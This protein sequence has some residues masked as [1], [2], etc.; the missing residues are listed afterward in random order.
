MKKERW[1][2]VIGFEGLYEV[3]D[4]GRVRNADGRVLAANPTMAG[5]E[6]VHLYSGGKKTRKRLQISRLVLESFVG[7][8]P[9]DKCHAAHW[10]GDKA[11]NTLLN[12]RWATPKE[13]SDDMTRHGTRVHRVGEAVK[14]SVLTNTCV[15]RIRDLRR[16]GCTHR[17]ISLW[18]RTCL[19]NVC[20][21]LQGRTWSH[22]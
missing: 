1:K 19:S 18:M 13:N 10:D 9:P 17:E 11:N 3:S 5:Y 14:R 4:Q 6:G 16:S 8:A 21:I 7:S 2:S 22:V 15:E 12:L 20:Y